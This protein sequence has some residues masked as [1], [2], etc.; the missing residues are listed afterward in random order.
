MRSE[1]EKTYKPQAFERSMY[2]EWERRG[3]FAAK[4]IPGKQPFT[5]VMPPPN[6]TGTL[7][8]GHA[9]DGTLQDI[10]TRY[11]R[12]KG[13]P[14]LYLPGTDHAA[15]A[16]EARIV[17]AMAAEGLTKATIGREAFLKRAWDWRTTYGERINEQLRRLGISCDWD[18]ERFTMDEGLSRAVKTVFLRLYEKGLIYR[19]NRI[20]NWCPHCLTALS[21]TE[22]EYREQQSHL[23]HVRYP[24]AEGGPG[25]VVATTRPETMLGDTGVAVH[26]DDERYKNMI[27]KNVILPL[28]ERPIPVVAD[29]Y[30]DR[31][32]G[33]GAVKMTPAHDPNDFEVAM[34][35][36]LPLL[37]VMNDD[38]SMNEQAGIYA[39]LPALEARKRIV[40]ALS[41][42]GLL[43]A[44]EPYAHNVGECYRCHSTVEP[45]VSRQW[46]VKMQPL[47]QPAIQSVTSG[48][49]RFIPERFEKT[50]LNWMQG[51]RDWCISRQLWWGHR[52]P[53]YYCDDC[54][55][56]I[57]SPEQPV[58]PRC[59]R[60][61]R[62]DE[63]V[64]DTWF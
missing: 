3:Y 43:V 16:T 18:R 11:H 44:V 31:D 22:V 41:S 45:L 7:H 54:D 23:W 1:M 55:E 17:K 51:I 48:Q 64:L 28:M 20:I 58:C 12:M 36:D 9:M 63:D 53:A 24:S 10:L 52:I 39:G 29:T 37:R 40:E 15:I 57:V 25:I 47:A 33:T 2:T 61:M 49:I 30:V 19:G 5:I 60:S 26:P 14:T 50:Y 8:M 59:G 62:Q 42:S 32:F 35:H 21:D 4:R 27:G 38:G 46:F 6:I 56:M 13:D 34:R